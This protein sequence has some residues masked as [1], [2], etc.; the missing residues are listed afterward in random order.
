MNSPIVSVRVSTYNSSATVLETLNS[1][2]DQE[3]TDI[4]LVISDDGSTDD[5]VAVCERWLDLNNN[6]F[7]NTRLIQHKQ[8]T[9]TAANA[10]RAMS[11]CQGEWVKGIAADDVLLPS[12][13]SDFMEYIH[14]TPNAEIIFSKVRCFGNLD[15]ARSWPWADVSRY[16]EAFTLRQFRVILSTQNFLPAASVFM[17]KKVWMD[18]GGYDE[19]IP[20]IEDHPFWVKALSRGV[21]FD[22][23]DKETVGYRFSETSVSQ[24]IRPLSERYLASS[25]KA[26]AYASKSLKYINPLYFFLYQTMRIRRRKMFPEWLFRFVN[27]VNPAYYEYYNTMQ[28]FKEI[29]DGGQ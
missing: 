16:F 19:S 28:E 20:L 3:Y 11:H 15:A 24:G 1:I 17:K 27:I 10:N 4:E 13:I 8:N 23:L 14:K 7:V 25:A 9:G 2:K 18:L 5:S 26:V 12:C 21:V 22:F 6:R 29:K